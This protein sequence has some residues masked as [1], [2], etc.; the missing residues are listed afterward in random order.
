MFLRIGIKI[1]PN[2]GGTSHIDDL[3]INLKHDPTKTSTSDSDTENET[4][5]ITMSFYLE[6]KS[7]DKQEKAGKKGRNSSVLSRKCIN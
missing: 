7:L 6:A 4:I 2:R 5:D 1:R 3:G